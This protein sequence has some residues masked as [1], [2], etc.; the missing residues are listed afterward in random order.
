M[1]KHNDKHSVSTDAAPE[2]RRREIC[3]LLEREGSVKVDLLAERWQVQPITIRRDL[4]QLAEEGLLIRTHGGAV[5]NERVRLEFN[6]S[7]RI[8]QQLAE[9]RAIARYA[10]DLVEPGQTIILDTGTTTQLLA[11]ELVPRTDLQIVTNSMVVA[12]E[13][14]AA[15]GLN[16]ILLGGQARHGGRS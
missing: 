13:L 1:N 10:A 3:K 16:V 5:R 9:K 15:L 4:E 6:Y 14:R 2:E 8:Q 11:R 12:H 7:D